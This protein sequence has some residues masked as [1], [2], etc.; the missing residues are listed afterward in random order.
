[1]IDERGSHLAIVDL[2]TSRELKRL[3][4]VSR[5]PIFAHFQETLGGVSTIRAFRAENRFVVENEIRVDVNG[6]AYAPSIV[7]NRWLAMRLEMLGSLIIYASAMFAVVEIATTGRI[8]ASVVGLSLSYA[9]SITQS[10][11]E[12]RRA[13]FYLLLTLI[14]GIL[15]LD[16]ATKL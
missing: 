1:M 14:P 13:P 16:G 9:L 3:D 4:S 15:R 7:S 8:N 10:L 12:H 6:R 2:V 5:S 11:S